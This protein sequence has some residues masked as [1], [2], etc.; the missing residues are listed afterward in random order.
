MSE[1]NI[2]EPPNARKDSVKGDELKTFVLMSR[3][4][5]P[6]GLETWLY[7]AL[8]AKSAFA[9][10]QAPLAVQICCVGPTITS[11]L[12]NNEQSTI[13]GELSLC[14]TTRYFK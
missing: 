13:H 7:M 14:N 3:T 5:T 10:H 1:V 8:H 6:C 2:L 11:T 9:I 4:L 12:A